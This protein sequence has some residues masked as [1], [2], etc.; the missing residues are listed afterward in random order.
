MTINLSI[1]IT[2]IPAIS[3][4]EA[5]SIGCNIR[6]RALINQLL[7]C[8]NV[9]LVCAAIIFFSSSPRA[10]YT[11]SLFREYPSFLLP[12]LFTPKIVIFFI[13]R[14][15]TNTLLCNTFVPIADNDVEDGIFDKRQVM[16]FKSIIVFGFIA[17]LSP[18]CRTETPEEDITY[19]LCIYY[20]NLCTI[21]ELSL[22]LSINFC[23]IN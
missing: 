5:S 16:F 4:V 17:S 19:M 9:K 10:H 2:K 11:C 1:L 21:L 15:T 7:T 20:K 23:I 13:T 6:R 12:F 14:A 22:V 3:G 8:N 18:D